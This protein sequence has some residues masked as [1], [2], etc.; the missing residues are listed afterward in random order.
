[1]T[2]VG[3][4]SATV[5][6]I[7]LVVALLATQAIGLVHRIEHGSTA[8]WHDRAAA[9]PGVGEIALGEPMPP[10]RASHAGQSGHDEPDAGDD[11]LHSCAAIDALALGDGPPSLPAPL[12]DL[13]RVATP[14]LAVTAAAAY[15]AASRPYLARAPP[16]LS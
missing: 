11:R 6:V 15:A 8:A 2:A 3:R 12:H 4:P 7:W 1:M 16:P 10:E 9:H 5:F 14:A 13:P